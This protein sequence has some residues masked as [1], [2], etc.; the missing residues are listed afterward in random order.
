MEIKIKRGML[1]ETSVL[2]VMLKMFKGLMIMD[3][4]ILLSTVQTR[5]AMCVGYR[6]E[7]PLQLQYIRGT[8][9]TF[10]FDLCDVINCQYQNASYRGYDVWLCY[11]QQHHLGCRAGW[12]VARPC[13]SWDRVAKYT[14]P[15]EPYGPR[16]ARSWW[17]NITFSREGY[18]GKPSLNPL[19]LS[20]GEYYHPP[21]EGNDLNI[22]L[23]VDQS[24]KDPWGV[25]SILFV[26]PPQTAPQPTRGPTMAQITTPVQGTNDTIVLQV[27]YTRLNPLDILELATGY[28]NGN[29]WLAWIAQNA[30]EQQMEGCVA[31]ASAR[32]Q[33]YTE[34]AP[35]HPSDAWGYACMLA[36]TREATPGD[37]TTLASL[38]PPIDNRTKVGPF[39]P[40]PGKAEYLCFSFAGT[41]PRVGDIP[42]EWCRDIIYNG[43]RNNYI[44]HWAR[45]GLYWFC[46]RDKLL[47]RMPLSGHGVCAMV[48]LM[49]PL[50]LIGERPNT[51]QVTTGAPGGKLVGRR[52]G[53]LLIRRRREAPNF[54]PTVDSPTYIDAIGIPRGVPDEFKLADQVAAGFENIPIVAAIFPITPNKNVDRI[55]YVHYNILRLSNL[56]RD[57]VA[58]LAEQLGPTSLMAVQNR[59]ALDMLLAEK[60]GV[61]AMFGEVC[62]TYIPNNTA[63]DG[64][65]TRAL[66]GLRTLSR[67]MHAHSGINNIWDAWLTSAF[68]QWKG[69]MGSLLLSFA[70]FA[71]IL[72]TCGCCCIPC[73]RALSVR[74]ITTVIE[75]RD[76]TYA[77]MMPLLPVGPE[78]G[79][80][81]LDSFDLRL[82]RQ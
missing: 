53:R 25:V 82:P 39:T 16:S 72:V 31:C 5:A 50:V 81:H 6:G 73:L 17:T 30:R 21:E 34:P 51:Q 3:M 49:A 19:A 46:G 37:C 42:S 60:G 64:S 66:E 9:T 2:C 12:T 4:I 58:G 70:T 26:D 40:R 24:G 47:V 29:I 68:G 52:R 15:W 61:C 65:V 44:G 67:T 78:R 32:P 7:A 79:K 38:F 77:Q 23:G 41:G 27:D 28:K 33:L 1:G 54:D 75:K 55:N 69:L 76:G 57:A 74:L 45:S 20:I 35:L 63:P 80:G 43:S 22:L 13:E 8:P 14:G 36:L 48:R 11:D 56:T 62:C 18:T 10:L 71:A 59:L